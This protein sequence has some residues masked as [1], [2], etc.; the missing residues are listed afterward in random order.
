MVITL[1]PSPPKIPK[2]NAKCHTFNSANAEIINNINISSGTI[3]GFHGKTIYHNFK[4]KISKQLGNGKL[5]N[6]ITKKN[7]DESKLN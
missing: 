6:Q 3:V 4:E 1:P 2:T 7:I 5:L